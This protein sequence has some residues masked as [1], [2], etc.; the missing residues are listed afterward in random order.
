MQAMLSGRPERPSYFVL[1]RSGC[2]G[3][4]PVLPSVFVRK[5]VPAPARLAKLM[6]SG[7]RWMA[8]IV[9]SV[10]VGQGV[11]CWVLGVGCWVLGVGCWVLG[12]GCWGG[13]GNG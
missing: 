11:G 2:A 10:I 5:F 6:R 9:P 1:L 3:I 13:P 8:R 12:V 4:S 7:N